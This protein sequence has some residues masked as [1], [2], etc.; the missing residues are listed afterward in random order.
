MRA[1]PPPQSLLDKR[2][3]YRAAFC[4]ARWRLALDPACGYRHVVDASG[5]DLG[6]RS[7]NVSLEKSGFA[8]RIALL[9]GVALGSGAASAQQGTMLD[10]PSTAPGSA[11]PAASTGSGAPSAP[12]LATPALPTVPTISSGAL[13]TTTLSGSGPPPPITVQFPPATI[14]AND[15]TTA[16][17]F[18]T[19]LFTGAFAGSTIAGRPD[20]AVQIGD[21]INVQTFGNVSLSVVARVNTDG[22]LFLPIIG[23]VTL[24]NVTRANLNS[25]LQTAISSV[26]SNTR[27]YADIVQP[28]SV[29]VFVTGN[30]QRP[31]RYL[32]STSDDILYFLDKAGGVDG[33]RGS[34][35]DVLVRHRGG[36]E[37]HYDLYDFLTQGR[38]GPAHFADGDAIVVRPRGPH[39]VV[40]GLAANDYAFELRLPP[41]MVPNPNTEAGFAGSVPDAGE[42]VLALARPNARRVTGAYVRSVRDH[43]PV[44]VYLPFDQFGPVGLGDGD[45]VDF[46][47]DAFQSQIAVTVRVSQA[48]PSVFVEPRTATL[49]AVLTKIPQDSPTADYRSV[50]I[51]RQSLAAQQKV[52]LQEALLRLQED[53]LAATALNVASSAGAASSASLLP[54]FIAAA[55][56]AVPSGQI[57]VYRNGRF[58]DLRLEDGDQIV[59]PDKSDVV[60][61]GGE[62]LNP[63][64][65]AF[66]PGAR[67]RDYVGDAGGFSVAA[68][69]GRF[70][71]RKP[72][73]VASVIDDKA[74]PEPGDQILIIPRVR[75]RTIQAIQTVTSL[76]LPLSVVAST[77]AR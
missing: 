9:A 60:Q 53:A 20:Y 67:V 32:G 41:G 16:P 23:P 7:M 43:Q 75:G 52:L 73:G 38:A 57:A 76:L 31:G 71:L 58:D 55:N 34:F 22:K 24:V 74:V 63:G 4:D 13:P 19:S 45:H 50:Y 51:L 46:R 62:A 54:Q 1:M 72:N 48:I 26:Y 56:Q 15:G 2:L 39:V 29:G 14:I 64:G 66:R 33:L 59:I 40:T 12:S 6:L 69:R 30:I 68:D 42:Q 65:F 47:S 27:V 35:R 25:T 36:G 28:G 77:V 37:E 8:V 61:V 70:I 18:G 3:V 17:L 21:T 11:P 5:G 10:F 49:Q 44:S